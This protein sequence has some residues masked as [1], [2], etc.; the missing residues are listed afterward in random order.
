MCILLFRL[1]GTRILD[2]LYGRGGM[3]IFKVG[4]GRHATKKVE[5]H[6]LKA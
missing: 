2:T 5:N 1:V 3:K 4:E 6:W